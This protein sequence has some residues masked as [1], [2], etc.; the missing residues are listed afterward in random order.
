MKKALLGAL[1]SLMLAGAISAADSLTSTPRS[2]STAVMLGDG[3]APVFLTADCAD[4]PRD[5]ASQNK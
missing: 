4:N 5:V 2:A 3:T 1:A